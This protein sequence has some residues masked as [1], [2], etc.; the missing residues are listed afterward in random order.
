MNGDLPFSILGDVFL[1]SQFV[2]FRDEPARIGFAK[3]PI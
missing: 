3:K 1:K 2:V